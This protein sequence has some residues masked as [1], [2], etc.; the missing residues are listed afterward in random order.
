MFRVGCI[1][2]IWCILED[3]KVGRNMKTEQDSVFSLPGCFWVLFLLLKYATLSFF[4]LELFNCFQNSSSILMFYFLIYSQI[5][6][7]SSRKGRPSPLAFPGTTKNQNLQ[8]DFRPALQTTK[9]GLLRKTEAVSGQVCSAHD[10]KVFL[11]KK[12]KQCCN[13]FM[14]NGVRHTSWLFSIKFPSSVGFCTHL[15]NLRVWIIY[16]PIRSLN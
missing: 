14:N 4:E 13:E 6:D 3:L 8:L 1:I 16:R 7:K 2:W 10:T 5:S 11:A 15:C 12:N 9:K